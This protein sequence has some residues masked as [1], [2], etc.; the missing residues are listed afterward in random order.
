MYSMSHSTHPTD[1]PMEEEDGMK[2]A[3]SYM[4][5]KVNLTCGAK[6]EPEAEFT[7]MKDG[8]VIVPSDTAA[9]FTDAHQSV[10]QVGLTM[11]NVEDT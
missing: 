3:Y 11:N 1:R 9:I 4:T 2:Q 6:A 7:W 8:E 5:G 10:L